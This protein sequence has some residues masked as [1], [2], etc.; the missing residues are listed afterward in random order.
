MWLSDVYVS[1]CCGRSESY[2]YPIISH[3]FDLTPSKANG[4]RQWSRFALTIACEF[5]VLQM[6]FD[7]AGK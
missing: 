6:N 7:T 3:D 4:R 5:D 1:V 2:S